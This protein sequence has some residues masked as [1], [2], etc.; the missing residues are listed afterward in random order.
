MNLYNIKSN[1]RVDSPL[2]TDITRP[3]WPLSL[4]YFRLRKDRY[5]IGKL[6]HDL[7]LAIDAGNWVSKDKP[8]DWKSITLKGYHGKSQDF[9][10]KTSLGV[11]HDNPYE[12]TAVMDKC[13]YF[14]KILDDIPSDVYLTR[15]LRLGPRSRIKFHTDEVVFH[16]IDNIIRCH[17]PIVTHHDVRFQIGFP[18]NAPAEGYNVWNAIELDSKH[19]EPGYLWYT[20]V[21]TLHGVVNNSDTERYHLCIDIRPPE[22]ISGMI[23]GSLEKN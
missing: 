1:T 20:N 19:L 4:N 13:P 9:L 16:D 23:R 14:Q 12:Y 17:I 5:D 7:S 11:G 21:N 6:R 18:L 22:H 8:G 10:E 3:L 2:W 15:I